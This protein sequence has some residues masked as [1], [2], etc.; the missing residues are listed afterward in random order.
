MA[1]KHIYGLAS[2]KIGALGAGG[3]MGTVLEQIG[4]TATGTA[5]M[6][7]EDNQIT[8]INIEESDSP[9]ESI[10]SQRGKITFAWSCY[11]V[12]AQQLYKLFGGIL[13]QFKTIATFGSITAGTGYTN[14][15]YKNV[16]LTGGAGTGAKA[17]ITVAGG[18]V[19]VVTLVDGGYGYVVSNSLSALAANLGGAGSGFAVP[20]ATL[21]N[22]GLTQNT[23]EAPDT[24]PDLEMSMELLDKNGTKIEIPRIKISGKFS[25]SFAK[26]KIGQ[27]DMLGT[28]LQPTGAG[29]ARMK[30]TDAN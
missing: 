11:D 28:V 9:V 24:F 12:S 8:D 29:V 10:T 2:I 3:T 26:D 18:V 25:F 27:A 22:S 23:W 30:K 5:V 20:V 7:T 16:P 1:K 14:G 4:E 15:T 21:L 6:S 19:T 13:T 17:D